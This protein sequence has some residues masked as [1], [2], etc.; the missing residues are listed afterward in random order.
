MSEHEEWQKTSFLSQFKRL[1]EDA[2]IPRDRAL[3][4]AGQYA[5]ATKTQCEAWL[6]AAGL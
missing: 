2:D 5:G 6:K 1:I 3:Y 4:M